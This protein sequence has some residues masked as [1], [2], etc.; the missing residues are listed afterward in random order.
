MDRPLENINISRT[1]QMMAV[2]STVLFP[3][4]VAWA[5]LR[6]IAGK[7]NGKGASTYSVKK[8]AEGYEVTRTR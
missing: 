2:D 8:V 6:A 7:F 4:S 3:S 5:S 1:L